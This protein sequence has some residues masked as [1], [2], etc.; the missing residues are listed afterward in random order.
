MTL[1]PE[2][3]NMTVGETRT[4]RA[5]NQ[6]GQPITGLTWAS[7]DPAIVSLSAADPPVLS[8]LA[9]GHVTITAGGASAGVTVWPGELPEGT[10]EW[11]N[12]SVSGSLLR[13]A[14]PSE[15]GIDI[16]AIGT[17]SIQV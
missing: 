2:V 12:L 10:T 7:S 16:F 13:P 15:T 3:M 9:A 1:S 11:S 4:L 6:A 5:V 8:A 14:V 17:G